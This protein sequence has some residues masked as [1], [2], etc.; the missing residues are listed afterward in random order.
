MKYWTGFNAVST[1]V[2]NNSDLSL[3]GESEESRWQCWYFFR[4]L[5]QGDSQGDTVSPSS[6]YEG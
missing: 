6:R 1:L 3:I 4:L 5:L 2:I